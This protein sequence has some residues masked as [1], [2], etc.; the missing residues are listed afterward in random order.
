M[1]NSHE[2]QTKKK[3]ER[4]RKK[5]VHLNCEFQP[6]TKL[7]KKTKYKKIY[8]VTTAVCYV[9]SIDLK[10]LLYMDHTSGKTEL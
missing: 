1:P 5:H 8:L 3:S 10:L 6:K 7:L 9:K 4:R 2:K